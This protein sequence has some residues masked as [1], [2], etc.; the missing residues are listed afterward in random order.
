M[1][2]LSEIG[3]ASYEFD[4]SPEMLQQALERLDLMMATLDADGMKL[5]Y[6]LPSMVDGSD[7]DD[8]AG[9][10]DWAR[11][12]VYLS[13]AIDIAPTYGKT[14]GAETRTRWAAAMDSLARRAVRFPPIRLGAL[15]A[16]AGAKGSS[17]FIESE[18]AVDRVDPPDPSVTLT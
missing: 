2:A 14:V 15:P 9:I 13:L 17:V 4:A 11:A 1:H 7:L 5:G 8:E 12:A 18:D 10:P 16:G 3:I 6:A